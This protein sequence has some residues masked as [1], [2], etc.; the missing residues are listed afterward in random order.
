MVRAVCHKSDCMSSFRKMFFQWK[1]QAEEGNFLFI[2]S[3]WKEVVWHIQGWLWWT[4]VKK[5][6]MVSL[7]FEPNLVW[8]LS[9]NQSHLPTWH[10]HC[11]NYRK[12]TCF[13]N[14]VKLN[15][16]LNYN[17]FIPTFLECHHFQNK[18]MSFRWHFLI[19]VPSNEHFLFIFSTCVL[20]Y[21][22]TYFTKSPFSLKLQK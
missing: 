13:V 17:W 16:L 21:V 10:S 19:L 1:C 14:F 4:C 12:F 6:K 9:L 22:D 15:S 20:L 18:L 7:K 8:I 5:R 11:K 2:T 3:T